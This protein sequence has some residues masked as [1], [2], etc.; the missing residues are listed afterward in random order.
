MIPKPTNMFVDTDLP[1][2]DEVP[3]IVKNERDGISVLYTLD[4]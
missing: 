2:V 4:M 3:V 1:R